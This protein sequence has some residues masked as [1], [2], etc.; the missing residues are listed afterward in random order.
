MYPLFIAVEPSLAGEIP[1][2]MLLVC[3]RCATAPK[4]G[5]KVQK[6]IDTRKGNVE[7]HKNIFIFFTKRGV[8]CLCILKKEQKRECVKGF[9]TLSFLPSVFS[10]QFSAFIWWHHRGR[11]RGR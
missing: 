7:K 4:S 5:A 3:A 6:K 11:Y 1:P 8:K 2:R 9:D 10:C